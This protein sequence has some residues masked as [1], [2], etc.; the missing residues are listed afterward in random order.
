[1]NDDRTDGEGSRGPSN[2]RICGRV[3][4]GRAIA[5]GVDPGRAAHAKAVPVSTPPATPRIGRSISPGTSIS[6]PSPDP[7]SV[8]APARVLAPAAAQEGP[9]RPPQV[10]LHTQQVADVMSR[11]EKILDFP[12]AGITSEEKAMRAMAEAKRLASLTPGEW[13]LWIDR[14][15]ERLGVPRAIMEGLISAIIKDSERKARED[16]AEARR[17]E[18]RIRRAQEREQRERKRQQEGIDKKAERNRKEKEKSFERL[19][20]LPRE[21]H[22][23]KLAELAKRLDEEL[24]AVRNDFSAFVG[25][26]GAA[27][28]T[29]SWNV[30][31]WPEPV[32][33][34]LLLQAIITKICRYIVLRPEAVTATAL[35][36]MT[37]WAHEGATH[38]PILAAISVEPNSGKSTLLGVLRFLVPKPFVSVE[39]TGPSVYRTVDRERPT[40]IIDEADDLFYRKSDLR[41]IVNAG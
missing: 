1:M 24:A 15:A 5:P 8:D 11:D 33:T 29:N 28:S 22:E 14:T 34:R 16:K 35:W 32:E 26:A 30:E 37:A 18:E 12:K 27:A 36:T 13:R 20:G 9:A 4:S 17:Q 21:Q 39:P 7:V 10:A 40:L 31:P 6:A 23:A 3:G 41:A 25:M 19:I 2:S 38:S